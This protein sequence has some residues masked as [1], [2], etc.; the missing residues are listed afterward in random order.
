MDAFYYTAEI[1]VYKKEGTPMM[2]EDHL[3]NKRDV[4]TI[5]AVVGGGSGG[6][7]ILTSNYEA[8]RYGVRSAMAVSR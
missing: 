5:P 7:V 3:G 1:S 4:D 2:I 6:G 8:R